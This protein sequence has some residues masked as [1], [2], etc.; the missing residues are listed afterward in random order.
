MSVLIFS[1][2]LDWSLSAS[3]IDPDWLPSVQ[4]LVLGPWLLFTLYVAWRL[5]R[6]V[7]LQFARTLGLVAP[8]ALLAIVLYSAGV[9]I[10]FQPMQM[11]GMM[12]DGMEDWC[13]S[14]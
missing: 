4:L 8:W 1:A 14:K 2:N 6:G 5:A 3:M 10:V 9:W 12:M 11:R 13:I 7:R